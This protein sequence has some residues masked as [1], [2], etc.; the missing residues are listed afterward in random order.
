MR[1]KFCCFW[2]IPEFSFVQDW[3]EAGGWVDATTT[4]DSFFI[5]GG[6][7]GDDANS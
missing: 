2:S 5:F 4:Q 6:L 3:P 7:T 1:F